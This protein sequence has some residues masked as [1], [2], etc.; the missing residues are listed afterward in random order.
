MAKLSL[1]VNV[2]FSPSPFHNVLSVCLIPVFKWP[3]QQ[4][5]NQ[6]IC[7][8]TVLLKQLLFSTLLLWFAKEIFKSSEQMKNDL[9]WEE[10]FFLKKKKT[11]YELFPGA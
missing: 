2:W 11:F 6:D 10:L 7:Y 9:N 8:L 3:W 1:V 5:C 4:C